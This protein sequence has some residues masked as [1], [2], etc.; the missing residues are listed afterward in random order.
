MKKFIKTLLVGLFAWTLFVPAWAQVHAESSIDDLSYEELLKEADGQTVNFYGWGGDDSLNQWLDEVYGPTLKEKYNI[1]LNRVPM[2]IDQILTQLSNEKQ[3]N[4]SESDID[5]IWINGEN[6][7]TARENDFLYGPFTDK[8]P[9]YK[10]Y[11]K[12]DDPENTHDFGYPIEGFE[13]PYSKA[14]LVLIK[15]SAVTE[16]TPKSAQELLEYCKANPGTFTYPAL[17]DFTGSAFV[18]NIIYEFV[19]YQ[20]FQDMEAD[21]EVV[22]AAIQ[23]ALDYLNELKPYLWSEGKT[24]PADAPALNNLFMDGEVAFYQTYGAYEIANQIEKGA[25]P[26]TAVSFVFDKGTI[27]NTSFIAIG[28]NASHKAAAIVAINEMLSPEMQLSKYKEIGEI[29][30]LENDQLTEEQKA[31]FDEVDPGKGTLGQDELLDHRLPEMPAQLVPI[32]EEIWLEEV[33][34]K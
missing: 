12:A 26:E 30:V 10:D 25:Y 27:G 14:Q 15:D 24:Y 20:E 33:A 5:M 17:P 8:M 18:R 3:A 19:D 31:A 23:P 32:I 4:A 34:G 9:N 28:K 29:P 13:A 21:K 1:T 22:K 11:V 6:F 2:D 16:A 7:K